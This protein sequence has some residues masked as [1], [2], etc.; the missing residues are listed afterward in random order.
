MREHPTLE[1]E[2]IERPVLGGVIY[3]LQGKLIGTRECYELLESVRDDVH[4]GVTPVAIDLSAVERVTSPGIGI[5][6]ACYTSLK[7]ANGRLVLLATPPHVRSLLELVRLWP[8]VE[9]AETE[10]D[11]PRA[12]G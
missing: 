10:Q 9:H 6:A 8:L 4:D 3:R 2:R 12:S 11:L 5:L 1:F 7:R